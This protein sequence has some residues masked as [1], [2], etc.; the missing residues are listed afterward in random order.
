MCAVLV[1]EGWVCLWVVLS[2]FQ[3]N[4]IALAPVEIRPSQNGGF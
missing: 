4:L 3:D 2:G 1:S